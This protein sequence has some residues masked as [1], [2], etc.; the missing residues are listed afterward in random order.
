MNN[1]VKNLVSLY[2]SVMGISEEDNEFELFAKLKKLIP[3]FVLAAQKELDAWEQDEN[4][5]DAMLGV[6]GI[7]QDIADAMCDVCSKN[8]IDC[9]TFSAEMGEQHVWAIAYDEES[10]EAYEV[11]ISPYTY[12][13]G[14]GYTW[15]KI[16]GVE[17]EDSDIILGSVN[18]DDFK[19][20]LEDY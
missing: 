3:A 4:G 18:W 16:S 9:M 12:E 10:E 5:E 11:D 6:G 13:T 1:D 20:N 14:G 8:R 7:C 19:G 15:R 17:I 2:E